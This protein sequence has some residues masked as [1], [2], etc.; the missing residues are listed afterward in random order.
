MALFREAVII[1]DTSVNMIH[2][3]EYKIVEGP[4]TTSETF[5]EDYETFIN[6]QAEDYW[7]LVCL[8]QEYIIFKRLKQ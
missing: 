1:D 3:Y 4:Y 7:E 6:E 5:V 8:E 2:K